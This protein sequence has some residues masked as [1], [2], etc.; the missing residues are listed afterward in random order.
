MSD[1]KMREEFE[2]SIIKVAKW[3]TF[4]RHPDMVA[5]YLDGYVDYAWLGYQAA[6]AQQAKKW[7]PP[8]SLKEDQ[9]K[10][11]LEGRNV[12]MSRECGM[13]FGNR[14]DSAEL[15]DYPECPMCHG[16]G[17]A[18]DVELQNYASQQEQNSGKQETGAWRIA[19][20]NMVTTSKQ[21]RDKWVAHG[22]SV[23]ELVER[24]CK[25][26]GDRTG[27]CTVRE[28]TSMLIAS[29]MDACEM[30]FIHENKRLNVEIKITKINL[31]L[32]RK[33]AEPQ[34]VGDV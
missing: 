32:N 10:A 24:N 26:T 18:G 27:L 34:K 20:I 4:E 2:S 12:F 29:G 21:E 16:S 6:L 31:I 19:A 15:Q 17:C 8:E 5:L 23:V 30:S 22:H 14:G 25:E 9:E 13:V 33:T 3:M 28:A 1:N 11:R 7:E